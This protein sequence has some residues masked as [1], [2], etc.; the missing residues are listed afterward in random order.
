MGKAQRRRG[1]TSDNKQGQRARKVKKHTRM[2]DQIVFEDMLPEN[3]K[4]L[5]NLK[6]DELLP[7]LGQNYCVTCV[8]HF[9]SEH[10]L[11]EHERNKEHKK[12]LKICLTEKPYTIEEAERA[13]GLMAAKKL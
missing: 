6:P 12:R 11:I 1:N 9:I 10:A 2:I 13:G 3:T 5:K 8:R 4:I 7:G